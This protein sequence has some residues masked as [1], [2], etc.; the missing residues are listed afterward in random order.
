[1]WFIHW[2]VYDHRPEIRP[3]EAVLW[4]FLLWEVLQTLSV[5][6][7]MFCI[8]IYCDIQ[9][10]HYK[11][12]SI[13]CLRS[14]PSFCLPSI[15][16]FILFFTF[17]LLSV[18]HSPVPFHAL[19]PFLSLCLCEGDTRGREWGEK[20]V[21]FFYSLPLIFLLDLHLISFLPIKTKELFFLSHFPSWEWLQGPWHIFTWWTCFYSRYNYMR[22]KMC[23][24]IEQNEVIFWFVLAHA[25]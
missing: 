22:D 17:F 16:W 2:S 12:I 15:F 1:M 14:T 7:I 5:E 25:E 18:Y 21:F 19:S 23:T 13:R 8:I 4:E 3:L 11:F 10:W 9:I 20:G 6:L 24:Y